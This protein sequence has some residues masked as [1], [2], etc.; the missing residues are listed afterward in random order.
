MAYSPSLESISTLKKTKLPIVVFDT[1]PDFDFSWKQNPDKIMYNHG[2]HG[3][4]DMC[5]LLRRANK[6]F[7]LAAGH[8]QNPATIK[9]LKAKIKAACVA[10]AMQ[11]MRVGLIGKPFK[12]MGDF[13]VPQNL[14]RKNGITVLEA[15]QEDLAKIEKRISSDEVE[16]ELALMKNKFEVPEGISEVLL[17]SIETGLVMRKW[18]E[19]KKLNAW[20]INFEY[21]GRLNGLKLMPFLEVS[22]AFARKIGY[23]G[24]GDVLTAALVAALLSVYPETTFAEMFCPDWKNGRIFLSHMGEW[25]V[26][27]AHKKP[28]IKEYKFI[29]GKGKDT[30]IVPGCLKKGRATFV[31]LAPGVDGK[32]K[33]VLAPGAMEVPEGTDNMKD[34]VHGWFK[35]DLL[36][37]DEFL[38][39]YSEIGATHHL[40]L[41]YGDVADELADFAKLMQWDVA[42][43]R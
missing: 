30:V 42:F 15:S 18:L 16:S 1:T 20:T 19:D 37:L 10:A 33:L 38:T 2:I 12:G 24:E 32:F 35:P 22:L 8:W 3:V 13:R 6:P 40:A 31:N 4:Q 21:A 11:K 26:A 14:L 17:S 43:I 23:A 29:F 25:N 41:V 5:N 39:A 36:P 27:L 34:T 9:K 28:T 7:L